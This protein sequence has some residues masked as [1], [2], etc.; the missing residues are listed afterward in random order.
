[1]IRKPE[2]QSSPVTDPYERYWTC[3][4]CKKSLKPWVAEILLA[5]EGLCSVKL[6]HV[7]LLE[8]SALINNYRTADL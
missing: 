7:Y 1:M 8:K 5:L 6:V 4:Y 2:D 3:R